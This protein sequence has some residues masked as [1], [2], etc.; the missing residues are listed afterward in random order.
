M[1]H[2]LSTYSK[3]LFS[4]HF[5]CHASLDVKPTLILVAECWPQMHL[6]TVRNS[7]SETAAWPSRAVGTTVDIKYAVAYWSGEAQ[8]TVTVKKEQRI[9]EDS[10]TLEAYGITDGSASVH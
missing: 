2:R 8:S 5:K 7:N 6:V 4:P 3:N 10:V 1:F 9:L